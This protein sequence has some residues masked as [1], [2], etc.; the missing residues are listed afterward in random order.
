M[1]TTAWVEFTS[2]ATSTP[3]TTNWTNAANALTIN[4][5]YAYATIADDGGASYQL[6]VTNPGT[7]LDEVIGK[8]IDGIEVEVRGTGQDGASQELVDLDTRLIIGGTVVGTDKAIGTQWTDASMVTR[9][10]GG[11]ADLWGLT[12][13]DSDI[14]SSTFGVEVAYESV[15]GNAA[16]MRIATIRVRVTYSDPPAGDVTGTGALTAPVITV[17]GAGAQTL[18]GSG[19][20]TAPVA[21]VSGAGTSDRVGSG[22]LTAPAA[23]VSGAGTQTVSGTGALTGTVPEVDGTGASAQD[24]TGYGDLVAP[25]AEVD[26]AGTNTLVIS[27]NLNAPM[28]TILADADIESGDVDGTGAPTA[29]VAEVDGIGIVGK[30]GTGALVAPEATVSGTGTQTVSGTGA[31]TAPASYVVAGTGLNSPPAIVGTAALTAPAATVSGI[32]FVLDP[33]DAP[34]K[35]L[36]WYLTG[37]GGDGETQRD[38]ALSLGGYRSNRVAQSMTWDTRDPM[39]GIEIVE[40]SGGNGRGTGALTA[41]STSSVSWT[42]PNG[43]AGAAV[44]ILNGETKTVYDLDENAWIRVRRVSD[45][46]LEGAHAVTC[47]DCF[48]NVLGMGNVPSA[49][50]VSGEVYYRAIMGKNEADGPAVNL[51]FWLDAADNTGIAIGLESAVSQ[52]IQTI[53][54]ETTAPTGITWSTATTSAAGLTLSAVPAGGLFGLWIR[55]TIA[56]DSDPS[57]NELVHIHVEFSDVE[58]TR[59]DALRGRY[60]IARADAIMEGVWIGQDAAPDLS[61]AA[62]ETWTSRPHT[63]SLSLDTGHDYHCVIRERNTYGLWSQNSEATVLRL[64]AAGGTDPTRPTAPTDLRVTQTS[65]D[66]AIIGARYQ[67]A[68][69]GTNRAE[70][71]VVWYTA[72]GTTPDPDNDT[73]TGYVKMRGTTGIEIGTFTD[74]GTVLLDGTPITAIVR[75]R[76]L[77]VEAGASFQPNTTQLP[78]SGAGS[79]VVSTEL[80]GWPSSG[81]LKTTDIHGSLR[82]VV[83]YSNLVV[84]AGI[85]TFTVLSGGRAQWG[86]TAEATTANTTIFEVSA[87]DS[88]NT[89]TVTGEIDALEPGRP[90]GDILFGTMAKQTQAPTAGPDGVTEEY[91]DAGDNI[92]LLL[93]E[94]WAEFWIDTVLVWKVFSDREVLYIPSE[95]DLV[96]GAV[97]GAGASTVFEATSATN[98][99]ITVNEVRKAHVDATAMTITAPEFWSL[100]GL[101]DKAPQATTWPQYGGSL[102]TVWDPEREDYRP[103]L[104]L[105]SDGELK[106]EYGV[107]NALTQAEVVA[108]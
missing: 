42:S 34:V 16:Q 6:K 43:T 55:R 108:L 50:A 91:I 86:T 49:D 81:Y 39:V 10:Y 3:G 2:A 53:A 46:P 7:A 45:I 78:A 83:A 61:A 77:V 67:P 11:A 104:Q 35:A 66:E 71:F 90:W 89:A 107:N 56:A 12:P 13:D 105:T 100:G 73:P 28:P 20:L 59:T 101:P 97:S 72:D 21:T 69:D 63:T 29:P 70:I 62:D 92:Y 79:I 25:V 102:I 68:P 24:V 93:G 65:D 57:A 44:T 41:E 36:S 94:G 58:D 33:T 48:N 106:S 88:D 80:A 4:T 103:F 76:R 37:A 60:R 19:A 99:Y 40:L 30:T 38:Q 82:E 5:N 17:S 15:G 27:A 14:A 22:A 95:W 18:D 54:D 98:V 31:L 64:N 85:S 26:G 74:T 47:L 75:T 87:L 8:Q 96:A 1:A 32:G 84:G 9:V 52:A 23:T 51:R